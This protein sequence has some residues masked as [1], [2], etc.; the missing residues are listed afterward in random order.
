M[1]SNWLTSGPSA[2]WYWRRKIEDFL[3]LSG[4]GER[5]VATEIAEHDDDLTAMAFEDF[6]VSLRDDE[7]G[8]LRRQ[9]PFQPPDAPQFLDLLGDPRLKPMV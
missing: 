6:L 9:K 8:K 4:L 5:R 7:L 1:P 3:G 2:P